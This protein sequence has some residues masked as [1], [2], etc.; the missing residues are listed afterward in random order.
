LQLAADDIAFKQY[1]EHRETRRRF[2]VVPV[3]SRALRKNENP[4]KPQMIETKEMQ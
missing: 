4:M 2:P 3:Q 1:S